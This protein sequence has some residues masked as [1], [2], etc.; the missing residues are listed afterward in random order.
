MPSKFMNLS[1]EISNCKYQ[2][3]SRFFF[4]CDK[5]RQAEEEGPGETNNTDKFFQKE[6]IHFNQV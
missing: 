3:S 6:L 4:K 1:V 5:K 2:D